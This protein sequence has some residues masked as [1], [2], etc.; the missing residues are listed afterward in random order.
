MLDAIRDFLFDL[1]DRLAWAPDWLI[2]LFVLALAALVALS[3]HGTIVR[4]LRR[5]LRDRYPYVRN[6]LTATKG[7]TRLATL[8]ILLLIAL[9]VAPFDDNVRAGIAKGLLL[10][11]IALIGWAAITA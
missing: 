5:L 1:R 7:L 3:I 9:P 2:G 4:V 10:V 11:G 6:F 8:V